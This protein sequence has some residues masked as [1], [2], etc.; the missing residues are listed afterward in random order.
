MRRPNN[1]QL[2]LHRVMCAMPCHWLDD[3]KIFTKFHLIH[4][5]GVWFVHIVTGENHARPMRNSRILHVATIKH[6]R[7]TRDIERKNN[8]LK[9]NQATNIKLEICFVFTRTQKII[10]IFSY[11]NLYVYV[12]FL[13]S[14]QRM[15]CVCACWKKKKS[16]SAEYDRESERNGKVWK[17]NI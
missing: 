15:K 14:F 1:A 7:P 3:V 17:E 2:S 11:H 9:N 10:I 12:L 8:V 13:F 6:S 16:L 4:M 5:Y